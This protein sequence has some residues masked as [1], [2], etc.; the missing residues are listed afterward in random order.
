MMK[1]LTHPNIIQY[2]DH[3]T[4]KRHFCI[5]MTLC[6]GGDLEQKLKAIHIKDK[7]NEDQVKRFYAHN[8][9]L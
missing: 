1:Q 7:P 4:Y 9:L 6:D 8:F 5:V 3:F 2:I